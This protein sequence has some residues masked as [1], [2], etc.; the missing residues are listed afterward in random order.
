MTATF[1]YQPDK[2]YS[3]GQ[4]L[5]MWLDQSE[6]SQ[7]ELARRLSLSPKHINQL[8]GGGVALTPDVAVALEQ[9]TDIPASAWARIEADYRSATALRKADAALEAHVDV[10]EQ[11]PIKEMERRNY[12]DQPA[13]TTKVAKL[14]QLLKFFGV[15]DVD[16]LR[17]VVVE[18]KALRASKAFTRSDGALAAWMRKAELIAATI[19]TDKFHQER[20][21]EALQELRALTRYDG[22]SWRQPLERICADVG[23]AVVILKELPGCRINGA[24]QWLT[25]GRAMVA[26]S[27]R[28]RRHDIFWFT[29]FHELGHLLRH[30]KRETFIDAIGA[31]VDEDLERDADRFASRLLI[32]PEYESELPGLTDEK[33]IKSFAERIGV[34]PSIV[35]GRLHHEKLAP[36]SRWQHLITRYQFA[37]D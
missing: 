12:Y 5:A 33:A 9:V 14:R 3:P 19:P 36:P 34:A 17:A 24:T 30:S 16:A 25:P 35:V 10:L 37:D 32:P 1:K 31:G 11:F 21:S 22:V 29:F 15:A 6:M 13:A 20:C 7:A 8:V 26:L 4:H 23:I 18:P 28:H 27:L 2:L